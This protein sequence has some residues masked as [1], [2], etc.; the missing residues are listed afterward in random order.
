V[1][2][3][4]NIA[5]KLLNEMR[6]SDWIW[7]IGLAFL[8]SVCGVVGVS[9]VE[10][11]GYPTFTIFMTCVYTAVFTCVAALLLFILD[12]MLH[13]IAWFAAGGTEHDL[14]DATPLSL[15]QRPR[16]RKAHALVDV[17]AVRSKCASGV[18]RTHRAWREESIFASVTPNWRVLSVLIFA[19][20][21]AIFWLPWYIANFPGGTYWDTYY[22]IFQVYP[23]N[24]PIAIIPWGDIYDQTLTDAWLV[25]HHPILTTMI[26]GAFGWI[27]DQL[28]GN[29]MAGVALFCA[30]QGIVHCLVFSGAVAWI[31]ERGCPPAV[32]FVIYIFLCIMPFISTWAMCMVKDSLFGVLFVPYILILVDSILTRGQSLMKPRKIVGFTILALFLCLT[33]KQ[34]IYVVVPTALVAAWLL[35]PKKINQYLAEGAANAISLRACSAWIHGEGARALARRNHGEGA[36]S[37]GSTSAAHRLLGD[38]GCASPAQMRARAKVRAAYTF[39]KKTEVTRPCVAYLC[40]A[41]ACLI[42][43]CLVMPYVVFPL[44]NVV[45]GGKQEALGT[46]FQQTAR[47]VYDYPDE[48]EF[49][50]RE[51]ID[52]VLDYSALESAYSWDFQDSVKYRYNLDATAQD[53][54]QYAAT[55]FEM[56]LKHP[57]SYFGSVACLA[58][59]YFAPTAYANIRM[60]TVDTKMGDDQRYMLWNPTELEW[61]RLGLDDL[62]YRMATNPG[63]DLPVLIVLYVFWLP[64]ALLYTA[65]RHRLQAGVMFVPFVILL[66]F[67]VVAPVYDARYCVPIFDAVPFLAAAVIIMLKDKVAHSL[68]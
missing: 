42:V 48:V 7:L 60:V 39:R 3:A 34:G 58:G 52:A 44:L 20:I 50:E 13:V 29:W 1:L 35:R 37:A 28:T 19:C 24:H 23:E 4:L 65:K 38:F 55:Y 43:M 22:Q 11:E 64:A 67:C 6:V 33:K 46:L 45:P 30:L 56:G 2:C 8:I 51:A 15:R 12:F 62:Y 47:Y 18:S 63:T 36:K 5:K 27:S 54:E 16:V 32:C 10:G 31:K 9:Y 59:F 21:M 40:Q 14:E 57:E 53:L 66:A 61:L 41:V 68:R 25:D 17:R 26:Y 49:E